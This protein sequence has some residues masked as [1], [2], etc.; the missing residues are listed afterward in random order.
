MKKV[1]LTIKDEV[2]LKNGKTSAQQAELVRVMQSYGTVEDFDRVLANTKA[3][4]QKSLDAMANQYNAV[5]E[6]KLTEDEFALVKTYRENVENKSVQFN[7]KINNL[8]DELRKVKDA[9][10]ERVKQLRAILG[11]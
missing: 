6:Q 2:C 11:E 1:V 4:Y 7:E 9:S 5:A 10:E 3:E 8:T